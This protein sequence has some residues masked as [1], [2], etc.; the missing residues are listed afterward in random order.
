MLLQSWYTALEKMRF[1]L[2]DEDAREKAA[3]QSWPARIERLKDAALTVCPCCFLSSVS[4]RADF[5]GAQH[6]SC[7]CTVAPPK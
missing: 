5:Q 6:V 1:S 2:P 7:P 4:Q 3:G